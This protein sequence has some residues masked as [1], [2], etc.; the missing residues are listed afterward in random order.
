[1]ADQ[2]SNMDSQVS[3]T[4]QRVVRDLHRQI[5]DRL[6][7]SS[8]ELLQAIGELTLSTPETP[9]APVA[10]VAAEM[11]STPGPDPARELEDRSRAFRAVRDA[12]A[13]LDRAESQEEIL[14]RL[15]EQS[16][17]FSSRAALLLNDPNGLKGWASVGFDNAPPIQD[18]SFPLH[19]QRAWSKLSNG[20]GSLVL[21]PE[22][23]DFL[24]SRI[25][26][27]RPMEGI[28]VP[29]VLRDRVVA[30]L[31]A[32]RTDEEAFLSLE[33]LQVLTYASAQALEMLPLRQRRS[34]ATLDMAPAD[35]EEDASV[36][37]LS[38]APPAVAPAV[39]AGV[40]PVSDIPLSDTEVSPPVSVDTTPQQ[41][42]EAEL[43]AWDAT[44][45]E[46]EPA[47]SAGEGGLT[48]AEVQAG[49]ALEPLESPTADSVATAP[50]SWSEPVSGGE[51]LSM[52]QEVLS[53]SSAPLSPVT[54]QTEE[55][56]PEPQF[57]RVPETPQYELL[58][59]TDAGSA[60][61]GVQPPPQT[62]PGG[63]ALRGFSIGDTEGELMDAPSPQPGTPEATPP[64]TSPSP[65]ETARLSMEGTEPGNVAQAAPPA[66]APSPVME[67]VGP[68]VV[69][70]ETQLIPLAPGPTGPRSPTPEPPAEAVEEHG[71]GTSEVVPPTDVQGPGRAFAPQQA[72]PQ[73]EAEDPV[74]EEARRLARLLVS[75]IKLYNEEQ[76]ET[77]RR[78]GNIYEQMKEDIDRSREMYEERVDQRVRGSADYFH[79][80]LVKM[81]AGGD[82]SILGI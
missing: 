17:S 35:T 48:E 23:C 41:A 58:D 33:A 9:V 72:Q 53:D 31:Y 2:V 24:C 62:Q 50:Q 55:I 42:A 37:V 28:L 11:P 7:E 54:P 25:G 26:A 3:A 61:G 65:Q 32:D 39:E 14:A 29:L 19:D 57:E 45:G 49:F 68:D 71:I 60:S 13:N 82:P 6:E 74:H 52:G 73:P 56:L 16:T 69:G 79:Q 21:A 30:A 20:A 75:E 64:P 18:V 78:M 36:G 12:V 8:Q 5:G 70:R 51:E 40:E 63:E 80:E 81:L 46:G 22:D 77:G 15:L 67:E 59:P 43:P 44:S 34:T 66:A 4:V 76:I 47:P 1:M 10:P 27:A 38:E